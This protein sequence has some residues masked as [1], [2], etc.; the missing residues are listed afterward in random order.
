MRLIDESYWSPAENLALDEVL[1]DGAESGRT[2]ETLRFW[3]GRIPFVVLGVSQVL[4]QE[5]I[6]KH[7]MEDHIRIARRSSAGGCVLQGPGCLN[8]SLVLAHAERPEIQTIRGSYCFILE[9]ICDALRKR[10]VLA[11]HKGISDIA[12]GGKKV[13]GSAQKRRKRCILHHGTLLY[14]VDFDA[15]ERYLREPE[16][17]PQYRGVRT[18]RGFVREI[19]L[20]PAELREAVCEAFG[21]EC[22]P[23]TPHRWELAK[24]KELVEEKYGTPEW[25]RRR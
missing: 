15:M 16:D 18:H 20:T 5:V 8:F 19:P 14:R 1:L 9:S 12:V 11:H 3:E 21:V 10:G 6:E 13:S 23:A 4:R 25:I 7:C 22:R 2:G 24:T 17:R